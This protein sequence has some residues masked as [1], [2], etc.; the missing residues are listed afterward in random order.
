[1]DWNLA[2]DT[3]GGPSMT[4][5][6]DAAVIINQTGAEFYKQPIFYALGHFSKFVPPGAKRVEVITT[7]SESFTN[8]KSKNTNEPTEESLMEYIA[9]LQSK[10][11]QRYYKQQNLSVT[12]EVQCIAFVNPDGSY[13]A[14]ILNT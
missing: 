2:L 3:N 12:Q 11:S 5:D 13:T 10:T 9:S 6:I 14:I 1:M 7:E 4:Y 8:K